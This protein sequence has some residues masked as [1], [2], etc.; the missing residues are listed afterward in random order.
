MVFMEDSKRAAELAVRENLETGLHINLV[1]PYD[2]PGVPESVRMSHSL[3]ADHFRNGPWTQVVY[4]PFITKAVAST[5]H[6]QLDEY[7]RLFGKEPVYFNGHKHFHL[8]LNMIF[9]G[10]LPPG[11]AVRRSFTFEKREKT[12]LNRFYRRLVDAWLL[13]RH[14]STDAFF[15]LKPASD[16]TRLKRVISL[17]QTKNIEL[18]AHPWSPDQF[19]FLTG[20]EFRL[21]IASA[22][23]VSFADL[24][25]GN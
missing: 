13:K 20:S 11:S 9:G 18:M 19:A 5:F 4:N 22:R 6:S 21:M 25:S 7:R 23:L 12:W 3:A 10:V 17:A 1:L 16:L 15:S 24:R 2:A 8:S 14:I